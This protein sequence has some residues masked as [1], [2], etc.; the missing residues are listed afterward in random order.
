MRTG[1]TNNSSIKNNII[2]AVTF[3]SVP[4][5]ILYCYFVFIAVQNAYN[6]YKKENN[7][8]DDNFD[9]YFQAFNIYLCLSVFVCDSLQINPIEEA[10]IISEFRDHDFEKK[11]ER[12]ENTRLR[13]AIV[14]LTTLNLLVANTVFSIDATSDAISI[15][16]FSESNVLRFGVGG[17]V[18]LISIIYSNILMRASIKNNSFE[19]FNAIT[20]INRTSLNN[21]LSSP[22]ENLEIVMQIVSSLTYE[23]IA[24]GYIMYSGISTFFDEENTKSPIGS[25]SIWYAISATAWLTIFTRTLSIKNRFF[26]PRFNEITPDMLA[27]A[28]LKKFRFAFDSLMSLVRSGAFGA[29]S[30][31]HFPGKSDEKLAI[32]V[33][34]MI[35]LF[36]QAI[37]VRYR[38]NLKKSVLEELENS[39]QEIAVIDDLSSDEL[40]DLI[41]KRFKTSNLSLAVMGMSVGALIANWIAFFNFLYTINNFLGTEHQKPLSLFDIV[42][43]QQL[44]G[45]PSLENAATFYQGLIIETSS[46]HRTKLYIEQR[47]RFFG[48]FRSIFHTKNEYPPEHLKLLL[49]DANDGA[50]RPLVFRRLP[51]EEPHD[52]YLTDIERDDTHQHTEIMDNRHSPTPPI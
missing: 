41:Q 17:L 36:Y 28:K 37:K 52:G 23:S 3:T 39:D 30:Y 27:N 8:Q 1:Q 40:F 44:W 20:M 10:R 31:K 5:D 48:P 22:L 34:L 33:P 32:T 38:V 21:I 16:Y 47:S 50:S 35:A 7:I 45:I 2:K 49:Q 12:I 51:T 13:K 46:Y 26:D 25:A 15:A 42:C 24:C 14:I 29:I 19:C 6:T 9:S 43:L 4:L 18:S 11:L